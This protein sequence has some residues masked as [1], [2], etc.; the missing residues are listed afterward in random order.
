MEI[1]LV[2]TVIV[3]LVGGL[4]V[5]VYTEI[6]IRLHEKKRRRRYERKK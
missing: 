6:K 5:V 3:F 1:P 2:K 4:A